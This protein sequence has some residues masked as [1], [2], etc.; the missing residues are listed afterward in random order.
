[1]GI[2]KSGL[3]LAACLVAAGTTVHRA[4]VG[5]GTRV[6]AT[7]KGRAVEYEA[8][9]LDGFRVW[10]DARL[11]AAGSETGAAALEL[12][13]VKL[14]ELGRA[15][16]APAL[17]RLRDVPLWLSQDDPCRPCACY[18]ESPDW[19]K[20][21]G[22]DPQK[23]KAVEICSAANFLTWTHEQPFMVLHEL[24]H[25]YHDRFLP[26]DDPLERELEAAFVKA[27]DS[28]RYEQVLHFD[29]ATTRHYAMTDV[30][31]YFAEGT[32]AWLGVN[33][34]YPFVAA[35]LRQFDPD[36]AAVLTRVWGEPVTSA[37]PN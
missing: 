20:E 23:A 36:L 22:F 28:G 3:V 31:E 18:H 34:F 7:S 35:E 1:M 4:G 5:D 30:K 26:L 15:V 6:T 14:F 16:R 8:R 32:E 25:A 37:L 27:Q 11:L 12:L 33:D 24:A 10:I 17:A 2:A 9:T 13:R 21:N 19:L 29:G